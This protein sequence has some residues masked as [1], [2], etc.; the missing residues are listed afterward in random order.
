[1][2]A[3]LREWRVAKL[4]IARYR[5]W[6]TYVASLSDGGNIECSEIVSG[7][8]NVL[9]RVGERMVVF[10]PEL[11]GETRTAEELG[12]E[13]VLAA[14]P[15]VVVGDAGVPRCLVQMAC[16][17]EKLRD[18]AQLR[19]GSWSHGRVLWEDTSVAKL[20]RRKPS[21]VSFQLPY[22]VSVVGESGAVIHRERIEPRYVG[23]S[24]I[25]VD[26]E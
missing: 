10:G 22:D 16:A 26:P 11:L 24:H 23:G 14:C 21:Q 15:E 3:P 5:Y 8:E 12:D 13:L 1:M 19:V 20:L 25:R 2:S 18:E 6:G 7:E 4:Q 17:E 9:V